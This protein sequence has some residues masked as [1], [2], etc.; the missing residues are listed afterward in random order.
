MPLLRSVG[1]MLTDILTS[2]A[3]REFGPGPCH[4]P[5]LDFMVALRSIAGGSEDHNDVWGQNWRSTSILSRNRW[6]T[7]SN[8]VHRYLPVATDNQWRPSVAASELSSCG[9]ITPANT[10]VFKPLVLFWGLLTPDLPTGVHLEAQIL[11]PTKAVIVVRVYLDQ[12]GT[13]EGIYRGYWWFNRCDLSPS[14]FLE[15]IYVILGQLS[16]SNYNSRFYNPTREITR[17]HEDVSKRNENPV[18]TVRRRSGAQE[19]EKEHEDIESGTCGGAWIFDGEAQALMGLRELKIC[20]RK[21]GGYR[22]YIYIL[23]SESKWKESMRERWRRSGVGKPTGG[24]SSAGTTRCD[25]HGV[26]VRAR[27]PRM[28]APGFGGSRVGPAGGPSVSAR[29]ECA[30]GRGD[31]RAGG[32]DG[33]G[34]HQRWSGRASDAQEMGAGGGRW[35]GYE[36]KPSVIVPQSS[37]RG[38]CVGVRRARSVGG[39]EHEE[40]HGVGAEEHC[41]DRKQQL[42]ANELHRSRCADWERVVRDGGRRASRE[43]VIS[44]SHKRLRKEDRT[45]EMSGRGA[46]CTAALDNH[47]SRAFAAEPGSTPGARIQE[48]WGQFILPPTGMDGARRAASPL[49]KYLFSSGQT[50]FRK[51]TPIDSADP[52][53]VRRT[54]ASDYEHQ[55]LGLLG[56]RESAIHFLGGSP[57][58]SPHLILLVSSRPFLALHP[59]ASFPTHSHVV[60]SSRI[61]IIKACN[62]F[63]QAFAAK[64]SSLC[65]PRKCIN[66]AA[67]FSEPSL[68][69]LLG[70]RLCGTMERLQRAHNLCGDLNLHNIGNPICDLPFRHALQPSAQQLPSRAVSLRLFRCPALSAVPYPGCFIIHSHALRQEYVPGFQ[71]D[72]RYQ[73]N[74]CLPLDN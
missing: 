13:I 65:D 8:T 60:V 43:R 58:Y 38:V 10:P 6:Q 63:R 26:T 73:F 40:L 68:Y 56:S 28:G 42:G 47:G 23:A 5:I 35:G 4:T 7:T 11:P 27:T 31:A 66:Y 33:D 50:T 21:S 70:T 14:V 59:L 74:H 69:T 45:K 62:C 53:C 54:A 37:R 55:D 12:N 64:E 3:H 51:Q 67:Q 1:G 57:T 24:E 19:Q 20:L 71:R 39:S 72:S 52:I 32:A 22:M 36:C 46:R 44:E 15:L 18:F 61:K 29:A 41:G 17:K 2:L 9:Y 25:V 34:I 16:A 49:S 30:E 48:G